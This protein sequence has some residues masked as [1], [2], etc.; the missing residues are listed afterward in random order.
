M[1]PDETGS[2]PVTPAQSAEPA[3][4]AAPAS[5]TTPHAEPT[6]PAERPAPAQGEPT[7][8]EPASGTPVEP[9][10]EP[11]APRESA[12][13][14]RAR[15]LREK[16]AGQSS[17]A[18]RLDPSGSQIKAPQPTPPAAAP[19]TPVDPLAPDYFDPDTGDIDPQKHADWSRRVAADEARKIVDSDRAQ[20]ELTRRRVDFVNRLDREGHDLATAYPELNPDNA[21]YNQPLD[22]AITAAFTG[23]VTNSK[24]EIVR[25]DLD[26]KSFAEPIMKAVRAQG[27]QVAASTQSAVAGAAAGAALVPGTNPP[28][29]AKAIED[30][31]VAELEEK[32]IKEQGKPVRR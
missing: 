16:A 20:Q 1:N 12:L 25:V 7:P 17:L 27:A 32:I 8:P 18:D 4:P 22:D 2:Q 31:S 19:E 26:L 9:G 3:A 13:Q 11:T 29:P 30:M 28:A 5:P 15:E 14:K 10:S 6:T 24:G 23:A 21:A